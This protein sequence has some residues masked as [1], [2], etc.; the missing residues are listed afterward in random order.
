MDPYKKVRPG[1]RLVISARAWN[2]AQEAADHVLGSQP[3]FGAGTGIGAPSFLAIPMQINGNAM[4]PGNKF[5]PGAVVQI[6]GLATPRSAT[7]SFV[8]ADL[9]PPYDGYMTCSAGIAFIHEP[10]DAINSF[11]RVSPV[12]SWGVTANG[13]VIGSVVP[14]IIRG[15]APVRIRILRFANEQ[16]STSLAAPSVRRSQQET[17]ERLRGVLETTT[18]KCDGAAQVL[19]VYTTPDQGAQPNAPENAVTKWGVVIL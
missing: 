15:V 10:T 11:L 16:P 2:R 3:M 19:G 13:G 4:L 9:S 5:P 7:E 18:C 8:T 17:V 14:V 1:E 12:I 6:G